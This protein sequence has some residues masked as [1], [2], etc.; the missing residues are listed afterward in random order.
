MLKQYSFLLYNV[1]YIII[2]VPFHYYLLMRIKFSNFVVIFYLFDIPFKFIQY[3]FLLENYLLFNSSYTSLVIFFRSS[4]LYYIYK[5]RS[6][7]PH[8][9]NPCADP[10]FLGGGGRPGPSDRKKLSQGF[11]SPQRI[12]QKG[13][14]WFYIVF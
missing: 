4:L 12:L 9:I 11:S 5:I 2:V 6:L 3:V 14:Q 13:I 8:H 1:F 7:I 10:V